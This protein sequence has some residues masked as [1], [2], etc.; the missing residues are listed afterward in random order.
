MSTKAYQGNVTSRIRGLIEKEGSQAAFARL[1]WGDPRP[2]AGK[3]N[4]WFKGTTGI[5][6]D[7]AVDVAK[8]CKVRAAWLLLGEAPECEGVTRTAAALADDLAAYVGAEA[9]AKAGPMT[10]G[11]AAQL[12]RRVRGEAILREAVAMVAAEM[13]ASAAHYQNQLSL[14]IAILNFHTL[15]ADGHRDP[16]GVLAAAEHLQ[17]SMRA[18][19]SK[20][21][22][23]AQPPKRLRGAGSPAPAPAAKCRR[24]KNT[25]TKRRPT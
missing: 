25:P 8:K 7:E 12:R 13:R 6:P 24:S 18:P 15:D 19:V 20:F 14:G 23:R 5:R 1:V 16:A 22:S 3:V 10:P 11:T 21:L 2:H 9:L 17:S 4:K